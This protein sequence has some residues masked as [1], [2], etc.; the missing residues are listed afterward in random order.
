MSSTTL[1]VD[2]RAVATFLT[3]HRIGLIGASDNPKN[4]SSTVMTELLAHGYEVVPINPST[5]R[6]GDRACYVGVADV[7]GALDGVIVMVPAAKS[8]DAVRDSIAAGVRNIWLF[9]GVGQ[10]SATREAS[11][12]C[13]EAGVAVVDG[14]CPLMFLEPTGWFHKVHHSIRKMRGD[15]VELQDER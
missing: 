13:H 1:T 12:I 6:V 8:A 5:A 2:E 10:G 3:G 4:F 11:E 7:P 15:M 14:A 9:R